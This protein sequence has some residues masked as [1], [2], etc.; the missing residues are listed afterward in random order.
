MAPTT[1]GAID[2]DVHVA[3]PSTK[4]LLPYLEEHW[5]DAITQRGIDGLDLVS[6]PPNAPPSCRPDWRPARGKPGTSLELLQRHALDGFGTANA[7]A[8]VVYGAQATMSEDLG[9]ALCRAVNDWVAREW[10]DREPRLRASIVVPWQNPHLAAEEIDRCAPDRRFVQVLVLAMGEAPLGRR[11]HWPLYEAAQR[12]GLPV[13]VHAG[14]IYRHA[15]TA[16]SGWPSYH[17]EDYVAHAQ[18]FQGQV[19]SLVTEGVFTRFPDLRMVLIESGVTWLPALL[20]RATKTWR[21]LRSEVPWVDRSPSEICAEHLRLTIQPFDGPPDPADAERI[22][23]QLGSDRLLLFA[24]DFPHWH[25]D[26]DDPLPAGLSTE[27]TRKVLVDNPL[28]TYPRLK[29]AA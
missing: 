5:A 7:I 9:A 8:N 18:A 10:L 16:A 21:A 23:D 14:S 4:A 28:E 20:W 12:H 25:F 2:C 1:S 29:E 22:V 13:G 6:F 3:V 27:L 11:Q 19:L 26:G 24:T 17:V 15:P